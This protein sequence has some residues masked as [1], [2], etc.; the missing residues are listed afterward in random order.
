M[1]EI[2]KE[3]QLLEHSNKNLEKDLLEIKK[4]YL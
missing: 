2:E 3:K 4:K 1:N